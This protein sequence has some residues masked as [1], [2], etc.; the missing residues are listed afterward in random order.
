MIKSL[1]PPGVPLYT[2]ISL[3]FRPPS[4]CFPR[5]SVFEEVDLRP[6]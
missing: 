3:L 4:H 5:C 2:V 6:F 1:M